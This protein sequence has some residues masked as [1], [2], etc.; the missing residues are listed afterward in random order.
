MG[1]Y[2]RIFPNEMPF[3]RRPMPSVINVREVITKERQAEFVGE[4]VEQLSLS[5]ALKG[6]KNA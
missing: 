1:L 5:E 3:V 6:D 2:S 4:E